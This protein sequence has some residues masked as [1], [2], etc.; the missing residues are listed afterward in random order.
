MQSN[1]EFERLYARIALD[2]VGENVAEVRKRIPESTKIMAVIK[3]NAYGHGAVEFAEYLEDKVE[4]YGVATLDEALEL[5]HSGVKK[6]ILILGGTNPAEYKKAIAE[7][8]T[9][10]VYDLASA[11][12]LSEIA[13]EQNKIANIHIKADT[14][15]SRIGFQVN[16]ESADCVKEISGLENIE[17]TGMFTHF[18]I[19]DAKD[20]TSALRQRD[21]FDK[22][23]GMCRERGVDIPF[24]HVN[25]SAGT[26]ELDRH[27]SMVRMGIMLYGLYPSDE[28]DKSFPLKPAMELVCHITHV[29][30]LEA[31]RGISYGHTFVTEK[32]MKV[33]T[34][35]CGY[36][37]GYPRSLSGKAQVLIGGKRCNVLGRICMDQMM[38][39]VTHL[40]DVKAGDKVVLVGKMGKE[41]ISV[42]ELADNAFSFNY[43]FVC[44]VSRR[45]PRAYFDKASYKKTVKYL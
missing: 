11:E 31:G 22:F 28:M 36:A 3:A 20:K 2:A 14:G 34:L 27:Y 12:K 6:P 41:F 7:N 45:V 17:I 16:E 26:M 24:L 33:A 13:K 15:M 35:P 39:D 25:N 21:L 18:A 29:K 40:S 37:D 8:I 30:E 4:W 43:E 23:V 42:E 10:A 19:A 5:R 9:L 38:V 44:D 1:M 32:K